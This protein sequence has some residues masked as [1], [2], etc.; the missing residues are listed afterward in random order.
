MMDYADSPR[1]GDLDGR[2]NLSL[3]ALT[4]YTAWFLKVCLDQIEFMAE[5]FDLDNLSGRLK[6]LVERSETLKPQ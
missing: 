2:G 3:R 4:E 5:L 6:L 1:Q